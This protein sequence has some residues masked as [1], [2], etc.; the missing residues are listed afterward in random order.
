MFRKKRGKLEVLLAHPGGP[1]F[2]HK[3]AGVWTIP[4]GE[5]G[6][7][8]D[9]LA[10]AKIEFE[11]ELGVTPSGDLIELGSTKQKGG[12]MVHAWAFEGDLNEN[13]SLRSNT[14]EMEWPPHSCKMEPFPEVDRASFFPVGAAREKI[15]A[16]QSVFLDRLIAALNSRG[17]G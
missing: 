17:P 9:L 11:E 14:F 5:V 10:R 1:Y 13:F 3:D 8:E 12:K 6:E 16:A 7:G 2:Q 4:K 15:N